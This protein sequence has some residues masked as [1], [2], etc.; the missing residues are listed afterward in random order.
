MYKRTF[1]ESRSRLQ[2]KLLK[3]KVKAFESGEKYIQMREHHEKEIAHLKHRVNEL[4]KEVAH[5]HAETAIMRD[6]RIKFYEDMLKDK[7]SE[8][9]RMDQKVKQMEEK[10]FE[11][12]RQRDEILEKCRE[13][14]HELNEVIV[15][16]E[17]TLEQLK[18]QTARINRDYTNSS[19]SSSM[20]PNHKKIPNSRE[21]TDRKPGG[22]KGHAHCPRKR[23]E[24]TETVV[25]P[26]PDKYVQNDNFR[27]TGRE[28]R[29]QLIVMN[30]TT[31]VIEYVTPEF[32]N[33]TTGQRVHAEFPNGVKDDV[34]YD[35]SVKAFA[36]LLN[37]HC[38]VSIDKTRTLLEE[39]SNGKISLSN[40][41]I[42]G[43]A[44]Q[45]SEK[46]KEER[47]QIYLKLLSAPVLHSDFTFGRVDGH[48]ANVII[49][50]TSDMVMYQ[51]REKKG[52]EGIKESPVELYT[53]TLVSD[54]E[55]AF[56]CHG[57]RHQE[58]LAHV[59]RYIKSSIENEPE[60]EWNKL[61][62][63]WI[64]RSIHYWNSIKN[65]GIKDEGVVTEFL[66]E[67]DRI[68]D[69]ARKEYEHK[70][71]RK[72]CKDGYNT[73][74]RMEK[75]KEDYVLFLRDPSV[76][77]TN[78]LAERCGRK[79][80]RKAHQVMAFRSKDGVNKFCDG[81]TILESLK[82][83]KENLYEAVMIRFNKGMETG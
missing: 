79:F 64:Q 30:M 17:K 27:P 53:G 43:L 75:D 39:I 63:K 69:K 77:P 32:R 45:F 13:K 44:R 22:Q 14:N 73:Y 50:A 3:N 40:G 20:S 21:K 49:T 7:N 81:L 74:L 12:L 51:G 68:I 76:P 66:E 25:I 42:C 83:K 41:M 24:P 59:E 6:Q 9:A 71:P 10:M 55:A 72:Y 58:C 5:A 60:F 38:Y 35:S 29:K 57:S 65:T 15:I 18:A 36:Y 70:P 31:R 19:I 54:H 62:L 61:M 48:Q 82:A 26:A 1:R 28:I 80:K 52:H 16:Q 56:T 46:T 2:I 47:N 67:Y 33:K 11:A 4:E 8:L 23:Q 37:N 34:N 78:N